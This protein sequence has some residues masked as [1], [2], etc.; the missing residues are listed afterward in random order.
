MTKSKVVLPKEVAE[1]IE[2]VWDGVLGGVGPAGSIKHAWLTNWRTLD[3][4]FPDQNPILQDYFRDNPITYVTALVNGYEVEQ[5]PEGELRMYFSETG[6]ERAFSGSLNMT[7]EVNY[8][9]GI[10]DGIQQTLRILGITIE[11]IN[12]TQTK[13]CE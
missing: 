9:R 12:D 13:G 8:Y 2:E 7:S 6:R 4:R 3:E 1:S 11:G 5:T 10:Q